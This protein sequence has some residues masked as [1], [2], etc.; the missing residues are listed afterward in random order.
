MGGY[1]GSGNNSRP[2]S[3]TTTPNV[4]S[5]G[6]HTGRGKHGDHR[7]SSRQPVSHMSSGRRHQRGHGSKGKGEIVEADV[8]DDLRS[9]R[10]DERAY[11]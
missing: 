7:Q 9:W 5:D 2:G 1:G 3:G 4:D 8:I 11:G 10:I 6:H